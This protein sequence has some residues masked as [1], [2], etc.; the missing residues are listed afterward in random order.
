MISFNKSGS[1]ERQ[2][3]SRYFTSVYGLSPYLTAGLE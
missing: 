3:K 2:L 1:R